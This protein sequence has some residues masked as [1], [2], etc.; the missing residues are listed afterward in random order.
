VALNSSNIKGK[1]FR[2]LRKVRVGDKLTIYV[3]E[4]AFEYKV[5]QRKILREA[6]QTRKKRLANARWIGE[7]PDERV[8]I[9]TCHPYWTNTHRL[10]LV[11]KPIP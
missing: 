8:T 6:F 11:A 9:V 3:G 1:V 10:V 2:N 4:Q 5:T 7:F